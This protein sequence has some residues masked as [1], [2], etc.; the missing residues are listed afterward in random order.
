EDFWRGFGLTDGPEPTAAEDHVPNTEVPEVPATVEAA[1]EDLLPET[2][3]PQRGFEEEQQDIAAKA[4]AR[5][6]QRRENMRKAQEDAEAEEARIET[7]PTGPRTLQLSRE[8]VKA[9]RENN[10]ELLV[11]LRR[12]SSDAVFSLEDNGQ[13][14]LSSMMP[15]SARHAELCVRVRALICGARST[16]E[17]KRQ[18]RVKALL[19]NETG[20]A[21][22]LR[23]LPQE[24]P[25][26][27]V[28][29]LPNASL[30]E[31]RAYAAS[32]MTP[33]ELEVSKQ[34]GISVGEAQWR[35]TQDG[36]IVVPYRA[37]PRIS[38]GGPGNFPVGAQLWLAG[39]EAEPGTAQILLYSTIFLKVPC[40]RPWLY[41]NWKR[42]DRLAPWYRT[43]GS[44]REGQGPESEIPAVDI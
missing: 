22:D 41:G 37:V 12:I 34:L 27:T 1:V 17:N 24:G 43:D 26:A 8:E 18:C 25:N 4:A 33:A 20:S 32:A 31:D 36:P 15:H 29:D 35:R 23:A 44:A 3:E 16:V 19:G 42:G 14:T 21:L 30:V 28:K 39:G 9:L 40:Y 6:A 38:A 13:L 11:L 5:E 2:T 7:E 10:E